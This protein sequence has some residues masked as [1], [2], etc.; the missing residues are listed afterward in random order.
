[1]KAAFRATVPVKRRD[2]LERKLLPGPCPPFW[3]IVWRE[4]EAGAGSDSPSEGP[5][6]RLP[7]PR[8]RPALRLANATAR[9]LA[10][11]GAVSR[12]D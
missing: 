5:A 2:R 6:D 1:M 8:T 12:C 9:A 11:T 3:W 4:S 10:G 7:G